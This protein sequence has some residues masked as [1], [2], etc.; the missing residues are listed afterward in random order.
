MR[1]PSTEYRLKFT[2]FGKWWN[3][4]RTLLYVHDFIAASNS[5]KQ[6]VVELRQRLQER[7][8]VKILWLLSD[9]G[10]QYLG[11]LSSRTSFCTRVVY[12]PKLTQNTYKLRNLIDLASKARP[13]SLQTLRQSLCLLNQ[14]F[15][16]TDPVHWH[17]LG[18][19]IAETL[20]AATWIASR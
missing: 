2:Q 4:N 9:I 6:L 3:V 8:Q 11:R 17:T 20:A 14:H 12:V 5:K 13:D 10:Y 18:N 1:L 15:N 16:V 19:P 7:F